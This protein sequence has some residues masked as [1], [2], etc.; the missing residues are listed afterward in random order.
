MT[1]KVW[2]QTTQ[3]P[4]MAESVCI[5]GYFVHRLPVAREYTKVAK[6]PQRQLPMFRPKRCLMLTDKREVWS[7]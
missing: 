1:S 2:A 7:P 4:S 5:P 3:L 6:L